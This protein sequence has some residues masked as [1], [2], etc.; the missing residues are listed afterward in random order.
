[1]AHRTMVHSGRNAVVFAAALLL[2]L[3][4]FPGLAI[5]HAAFEDASPEPGARLASSP[6]QITLAFTEPLNHELTTAHLVNS[7]SGRRVIASI[8][9]TSGTRLVMRPSHPLATGSF[10]VRWHTVSIRDGHTLEGSFG[11][12]VRANAVGGAA[13]VEQSPLARDGWLRV[14]LRG[15]WYAALVFFGGGLL[16]GLILASPSGLTGWLLAGEGAAA[17]TPGGR[18]DAARA[19]IWGRTRAAGWVAAA[20]GA[21]VALAETKDA[22]GSLSWSR[23]RSQSAS[24]AVLAVR[25]TSA[26]TESAG[27]TA[28][29]S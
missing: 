12:G 19:R 7:R 14:A 21:A 6:A 27:A 13:Q 23:F 11:F 10:Q 5:A 22:A 8:A 18:P 9:F 25:P 20:A 16:C 26:T 15:L 28:T 2:A 24:P 29:R 4:L 3:V 17:L 1:M